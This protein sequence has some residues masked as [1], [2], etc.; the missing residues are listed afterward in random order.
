MSLTATSYLFAATSDVVGALP[1]SKTLY[2]VTSV[3]LST[4]A[5]SLLYIV[6]PNRQ[7]DWR[8]AAWGGLV[9]GVFFEIAKR[10]FAA[11][12]VHLPSYTVVYGAIALIPIF[13]VWIYT[14]WM[15]TLF[16]A[17][18]A[19]SLPI[20][21]YERWWH[22]PKPGSRFIDAMA[23]LEVLFKARRGGVQASLSS[24][25]IRQQ[26]RLGFD[27]MERLL[28]QMV[29]AGWVGRLHADQMPATRQGPLQGAEW[30]VLLT[31]PAALKLSQVYRVFVFETQAEARL[32]KLVEEAIEHGLDQSI[33]DYF[34]AD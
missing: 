4:C 5:F 2:T 9:A 13:L 29:K 15:I 7:I 32:T 30:W 25:E 20:M 8:D 28:T 33:D 19:A 21:K 11:F 18:V 22:V 34:G 3:M 14:C 17:V 24:G 16:G 26:T 6:V 27:E 1:G 31:N 23:L 12:V 10:I